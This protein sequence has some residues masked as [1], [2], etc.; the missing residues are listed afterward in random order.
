MTV[1]NLTAEYI[2]HSI[3]EL[4]LIEATTQGFEVTLPQIYHNGDSVVVVIS[5]EN[6]GYTVHDNSYA[7]MLVS[8][9]GLPVGKRLADTVRPQ[10]QMYGCHLHEM[11]VSKR[12]ERSDQVAVC[13]ALVGGASRLIAD[14]ALVS[15]QAPLIDFRASVY[16]KVRS[17]VGGDRV[18]TNEEVSGSF[19]S[20]YRISNVVLD[21]AKSE[22]IA[23]VEPIPDRDS[24]PRRFK[25]FYDLS[26]TAMHKNIERIAIFDD[27]KPLPSGDA[28]LL[29]QVGRLVRFSDAPALFQPWATLQ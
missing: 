28:L 19:G 15:T 7:A 2:K 18:R 27:E 22:P 16:G 11:R 29:Q 20:T 24:I 26:Q 25:E 10:I 9:A 1:P 3:C 21:S 8:N 4:T 23:F 17:I 6:D 5:V 14:H 12:C 13:A